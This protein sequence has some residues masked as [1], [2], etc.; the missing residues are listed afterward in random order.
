[1]AVWATV[2]SEQFNVEIKLF[3]LCLSH[4]NIMNDECVHNI[5][6]GLFWCKLLFFTPF[7]YINSFPNSSQRKHNYIF[8]PQKHCTITFWLCMPLKVN[9]L[10]DV[11]YILQPI[12]KK[13]F[14]T[15][16]SWPARSSS[17]HEHRDRSTLG[18]II[19]ISSL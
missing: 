7:C 17:H 19:V 14:V 13:Q 10:S 18:I 9:I 2:S 3:V 1:M 15:Q 5:S 8:E 16:L 4:K 11:V 6:S 12:D